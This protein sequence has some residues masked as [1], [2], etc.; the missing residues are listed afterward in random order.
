MLEI[1]SRLAEL[2]CAIAREADKSDQSG[3][4]K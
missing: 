2:I 3:D 1:L 4:H